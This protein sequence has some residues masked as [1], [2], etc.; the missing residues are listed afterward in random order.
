MRLNGY[1]QVSVKDRMEAIDITDQAFSLG[2]VAP[3]VLEGGGVGDHFFWTYV[4]VAVVVLVAGI[5][6]YKYLT[7]RPS[8]TIDCTGGFCNRDECHPT[9]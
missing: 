7:R 5:V 9:E 4:V 6:A 3:S 8:G 1:L 2:N